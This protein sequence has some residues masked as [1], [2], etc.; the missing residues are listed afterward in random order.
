MLF[1]QAGH[2]LH[3]TVIILT[4]IGNVFIKLTYLIRFI[5]VDLS[6][7]AFYLSYQVLHYIYFGT[8]LTNDI[9]DRYNVS[10]KVCVCTFVVVCLLRVREE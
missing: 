4:G 6:Y 8:T 3:V 5:K 1:R 9:F 7:A 10:N 2:S